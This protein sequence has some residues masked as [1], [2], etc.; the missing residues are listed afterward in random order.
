MSRNSTA[1]AETFSLSRE[2]THKVVPYGQAQAGQ[3]GGQRG[4]TRENPPLT[5]LSRGP[6]PTLLDIYL[7]FT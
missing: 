6:E 2:L 7:T 1:L 5:C 4:R 3:G